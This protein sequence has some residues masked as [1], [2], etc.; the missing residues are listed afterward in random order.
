MFRYLRK[1]IEKSIT[2]N[3]PDP[4]KLLFF[5]GLAF[6]AGYAIGNYGYQNADTIMQNVC[7]V[8]QL[9]KL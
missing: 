1:K 8:Y 3:V 6:C 7:E 2:E 9:S 4:V 5:F